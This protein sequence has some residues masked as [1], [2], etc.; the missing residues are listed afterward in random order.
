LDHCRGWGRSIGDRS[1]T[2][3]ALIG[4]NH[5]E[6]GPANSADV[7]IADVDYTSTHKA[8]VGAKTTESG[9]LYVKE[10]RDGT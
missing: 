1:L 8:G 10:W 6:N 5:S 9:A 3:A 4:C 7:R 2:V